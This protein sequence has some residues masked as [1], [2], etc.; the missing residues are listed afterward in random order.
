[1]LTDTCA[2][3]ELAMHSAKAKIINLMVFIQPELN[4][5]DF[6]PCKVEA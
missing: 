3:A 1:M 5:K 6:S 4:M 2:C